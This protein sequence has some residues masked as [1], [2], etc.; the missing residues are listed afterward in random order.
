ML[1]YWPVKVLQS[2]AIKNVGIGS[3]AALLINYL[4]ISMLTS[5]RKYIE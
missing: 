1:V 2:Y 3:T 4:N 5:V